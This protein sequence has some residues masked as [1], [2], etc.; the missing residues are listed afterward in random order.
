GRHSIEVGFNYEKFESKSWTIAPS[1]LWLLAR[2]QANRHITG[3]DTTQ[4]IGQF[5]GSVSQGLYDEFARLTVDLP[6]AKFYK[7]IR[8]R[9]GTPLN[10]FINVDGMNPE[11]LDLSLFSPLELNDNGLI[12][13]SGYNYLGEEVSGSR[14]NDFFTGR[15]GQGNRTFLNPAF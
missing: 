9:T 10:D 6:G 14:F 12:G 1:R 15:D 7:A 8:E 13:Y 5:Q 4:I 11:D 3:V 2:Q